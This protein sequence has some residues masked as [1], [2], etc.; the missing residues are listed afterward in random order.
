MA[1]IRTEWKCVKF[2][3]LQTD[4]FV[5]GKNY[6]IVALSN[7]LFLRDAIERKHPAA[8]AILENRNNV[9]ET[10]GEE[11]INCNAEKVFLDIKS[12]PNSMVKNILTSLAVRCGLVDG[13]DLVEALND[14]LTSPSKSKPAISAEELTTL[15][16]K[17]IEL[18]EDLLQSCY[19]IENAP[20][21]TEFEESLDI[22][23]MPTLLLRTPNWIQSMSVRTVI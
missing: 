17:G 21:V 8:D 14:H 23:R 10:F 5:T 6:K 9:T 20:T 2:I 12:Q 19:T 3:W 15:G 13:S 11:W 18:I 7:V 22:F 1:I 4:A 16:L